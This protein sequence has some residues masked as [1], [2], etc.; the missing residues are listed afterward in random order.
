MLQKLLYRLLLLTS[1]V[2]LASSCSTLPNVEHYLHS[3]QYVDA[4][5]NF[6]GA[7]GP[8]SIE[9][10]EAI[11]TRLKR[12]TPG[13]DAILQRHLAIE[14]A[15]SGS[16]LVLGNKVTLLVNGP[17]TYAA[18]YEAIKKAKYNVNMETYI[19]EDN[20]LIHTL[21]D[22]LRQKRSEGLEINLIYDAY[23]ALGTPSIL[24][25][26][27]RKGGIRLLEF[28]PINP[29]EIDALAAINN[30]NHR[31]LLIVD[32]KVVFT[33]GINLGA[34]LSGSGSNPRQGG[35]VGY[36]W[37]DTDVRIEGPAAAE[38]QK[39]FIQ[40]WESQAGPK[41]APSVYFPEIPP[42]GK[43]IVRA[44][45][46]SAEAPVPLIYATLISAVRSASRTIHI[47]N[48]YFAP[49]QHFLD[50]LQEAARRG[51]SVTLVLPKHSDSWLALAAGRS[52]YA[53]LLEAGITIYERR[54]R[55]LHA[56]T[57]V[58]DGV[59]STI[60]SSNLDWRSFRHNDEINA[61]I[62]GR[63]FA[64]QMETLFTHDLAHSN[65]ITLAQWRH[66]SLWTRFKE[67]IA[68]FWQWW[69]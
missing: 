47:T 36:S 61:V 64:E 13:S 45:A 57:I 52:H 48:A 26:R 4:D 55:V 49:N 58:I 6:Y 68:R 24:F 33:G 67:A 69:L 19:L 39:A 38:F 18:M 59:W 51:V 44:I 9:Q 66:R 56:K 23:G 11:I 41:L 5:P 53:N 17:T 3:V 37:R 35:S 7:H 8:L 65:R 28:N 50:A 20:P 10:S 40:H 29:L 31:K 46:S 2:L 1:A 60:G 14:R 32:G 30:R 63:D 15:I 43:H 62:L 16:S 54:D 42:A 34:E 27:L 25:E 21:I 12:E 22:L